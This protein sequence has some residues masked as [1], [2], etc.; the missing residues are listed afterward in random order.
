M[1]RGVVIPQHLARYD[2]GICSQQAILLIETAIQKGYRARPVRLNKHFVCEVFANGEWH[3]L[4][5]DLKLRFSH[6]FLIPSAENYK[7]DQ[8][9]RN[10]LYINRIQY[11]DKILANSFFDTVAPGSEKIFAASNL[12][13]LHE[14]SFFLSD[15]LWAFCCLVCLLLYRNELSPLLQVRNTKNIHTTTV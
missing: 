15:Y 12:K 7:N 10:N 11:D 6:P 14:V 3:M 8:L 2:K 5:T 13:L 9:L 1:H 4:D